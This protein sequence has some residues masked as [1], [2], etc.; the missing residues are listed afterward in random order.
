MATIE[1]LFSG[2]P[3]AARAS[4]ATAKPE[5]PT[6]AG[7]PPGDN[8]Y[9]KASPLTDQF[10]GRTLAQLL[11]DAGEQVEPQTWIRSNLKAEKPPVYSA[12][13]GKERLYFRG[14]AAGS[15]LPTAEQLLVIS[16]RE[17]QSLLGGSPAAPATPPA[18]G[19]QAGLLA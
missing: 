18:Q 14:P 13:W 3:G 11:E 12:S 9:G 5:Q 8:R 10:A 6:P 17:A 2:A 1:E 4:V 15:Q 16:M 19:G 7:A